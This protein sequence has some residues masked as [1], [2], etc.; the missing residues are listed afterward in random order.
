MPVRGN[1]LEEQAAL[2]R[3]LCEA[4]GIDRLPVPKNS[5][6]RRT[7]EKRALL[8]EIRRVCKEQGREP[9]FEA[10]F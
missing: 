4:R 10:N 7:P 9:P 6:K 3:Q 2:V 1:S 5:G 8:R